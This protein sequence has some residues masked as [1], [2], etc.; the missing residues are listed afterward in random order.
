[1]DSGRDLSLLQS[2]YECNKTY[3]ENS[4]QSYFMSPK[5]KSSENLIFSRIFESFRPPI[6][7]K[8]SGTRLTYSL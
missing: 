1:M 7:K 6:K 2:S 5:K 4:Y 3:L 8:F